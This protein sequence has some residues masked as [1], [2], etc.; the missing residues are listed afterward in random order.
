MTSFLIYHIYRKVKY[1][2][3]STGKNLMFFYFTKQYNH[4]KL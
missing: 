3:I 2:P 1:G 4:L